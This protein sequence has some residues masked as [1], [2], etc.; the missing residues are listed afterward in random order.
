MV[1]YQVQLPESNE[2]AFLNIIRSL[3]SLGV[4]SSFGATDNLVHPGPA[5]SAE[6]LLT[7]L[8]GSEKQ[9]AE[10]AV[11]PAQQVIAY[12]KSWQASR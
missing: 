2:E 8:E 11:I 12:M 4:I 5:V 10:G 3:Q 6:R 7:I 1:T 9:V